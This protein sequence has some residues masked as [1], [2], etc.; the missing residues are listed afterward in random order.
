MNKYL[1]I[2]ALPLLITPP[3]YTMN[4]WNIRNKQRLITGS[5]SGLS[6][7]IGAAI[8]GHIILPWYTDK[9]QEEA[10][11][12]QLETHNKI[13]HKL[14]TLYRTANST[15][16]TASI[17]LDSSSVLLDYKKQLAEDIA[18]LQEGTT[19]DWDDPTEKENVIQLISY[20]K[21][22]DAQINKLLALKIGQ[23]VQEQYRDEFTQLLKEDSIDA[24]AMNKIVYEKFG[25][26]L[27][28]F[29]S[30]KQALHETHARCEQYGV[31][32]ELLKKIELL[33]KT[34]NYIFAQALDQE[35]TAQEQ[36][37]Q[38]VQLFNAELDN[39]H[40]VKDF[41]NEAQHHVQQASQT[42][43]HIAQ[44]M[45]QQ[46]KAQ[47]SMLDRCSTLLSTLIAHVTSWGMHNEQQAQKVIS[48]VRQEGQNTREAIRSTLTAQNNAVQKK[49]NEVERK[50][51]QAQKKA[52]EA[53]KMAD[54]ALGPLPPATNPYLNA[55]DPDQP[56]PSAPPLEDLNKKN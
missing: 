21:D 23:E 19:F 33:N 34:T 55:Q 49:L 31:A 44:V 8:Y 18:K 56:A 41:Y 45:E 2:I 9:R 42:V 27:Y 17:P 14:R 5:A 12:A 38:Q 7:I 35:R 1:C 11:L 29:S 6:A 53:H 20:L 10:K 39:K 24:T 3:A 32:P 16:N 54:T 22:H 51:H 30:Y 46:S 50:A 43:S 4:S 48:E 40:A 52:D 25:D 13:Q 15:Y 28:K 26:M 47:Q 37:Q 36:A